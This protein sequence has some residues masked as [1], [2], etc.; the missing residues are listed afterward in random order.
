[1]S[2]K[3]VMRRNGVVERAL[4]AST[5]QHAEEMFRIH[6]EEF[7]YTPSPEML[8]IMCKSCSLN[9]KYKRSFKHFDSAEKY[10][11]V[12]T[13]QMYNVVIKS[14]HLSGQYG[15]AETLFQEMLAKGLVPTVEIYRSLINCCLSS[16]KMVLA[17]TYLTHMRERNVLPD[18]HIYEMMI[19]MGTRLRYKSEVEE[20]CL[21]MTQR[22]LTKTGT[23]FESLLIL[24]STYRDRDNVHRI[25]EEMKLANRKPSAKMFSSL[26][27]SCRQTKT[28]PPDLDMAL[29]CYQ[30]MLDRDIIPNSSCLNLLLGVYEDSGVLLTKGVA[31][32]DESLAAG[33][34]HPSCLT[35]T[36]LMNAYTRRKMFDR[37]RELYDRFH[38]SGLEPDRILYNSALRFCM[39]SSDFPLAA[40]IITCMKRDKISMDCVTY[41]YLI[42]MNA[43]A[44]N[45][46]LV[47]QYFEE[48]LLVDNKSYK[49]N[50]GMGSL[51]MAAC[52]KSEFYPRVEKHFIELERGL[53]KTT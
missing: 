6:N 26:I 10:G 15:K 20:M 41:F 44:K 40:D 31:F 21:E 46:D 34:I 22:G 23:M 32:F 1:M 29:D 39:Y 17:F 45:Y 27:A 4:E 28:S 53:K 12:K 50:K 9:N 19:G 36:L 33:T 5:L 13:T 38:Q 25:F 35:Y 49:E 48:M 51:I 8:A 7:E 2:S 3:S 24:Y 52:K 42:K 18:E 14:C 30:K 47:L 37:S 43:R 16:Q 11:I